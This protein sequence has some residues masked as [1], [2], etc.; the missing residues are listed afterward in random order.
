MTFPWLKIG[1][2]G[3]PSIQ[4]EEA[5]REKGESLKKYSEFFLSPF[6]LFTFCPILH[7]PPALPSNF[8]SF[9]NA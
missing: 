3:G 2:G 4:G 5:K 6:R 8:I 7:L 9:L 1:F